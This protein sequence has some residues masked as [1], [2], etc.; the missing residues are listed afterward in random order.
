MDVDRRGWGELGRAIVAV[1]D[2]AGTPL[3]PAL[4]REALGTDLAYTTVMTVMA[5]LAE[6]GVLLRH[7]AGRGYAYTR[8][9]DPA[10]VTA[11][12]MHRLLDT[13][14]D[15]EGVLARFVHRLSADDEQLITRLLSDL[16]ARPGERPPP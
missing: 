5:R 10:E 11:R 6:R 7:R 2:A 9:P 16:N 8:Q 4:V 15:R 3:T 1:L 12:H 14:D 13:D